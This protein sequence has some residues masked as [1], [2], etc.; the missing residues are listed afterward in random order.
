M[1]N[2]TYKLLKTRK[3]RETVLELTLPEF[4]SYFSYTL[5]IGFEAGKIKK[6]SGF[7]TFK[8]FVN[9]LKRAYDYEEGRIYERHMFE[10]IKGA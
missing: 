9:A 3:G 4:E 5:S 6:I 7:K 2:K 8:Q 10:I 1:E